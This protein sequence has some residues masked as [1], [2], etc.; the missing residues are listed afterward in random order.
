MGRTVDVYTLQL[1]K[2]LDRGN[3]TEFNQPES[4]NQTDLLYITNILIWLVE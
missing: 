4:W 2:K 1:I 3:R